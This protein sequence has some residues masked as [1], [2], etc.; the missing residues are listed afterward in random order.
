MGEIVAREFMSEAGVELGDVYE[1]GCWSTLK[2]DAGLALPAAV[3]TRSNS[4]TASSACSIL[5]IRSAYRDIR[6]LTSPPYWRPMN[7]LDDCSSD[8]T[9]AGDSDRSDADVAQ[10]RLGRASYTRI[11]RSSRSCVSFYRCW[12]TMSEHLTYPLD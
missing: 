8:S 11:R 6:S 4:G 1:A 12:M 5:R 2:R 3:P 10:I 7:R 9:F